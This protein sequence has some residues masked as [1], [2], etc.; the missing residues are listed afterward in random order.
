MVLH[1]LYTLGSPSLS[2]S[3][4]LGSPFLSTSMGQKSPSLSTSME[5]EISLFFPV[6]KTDPSKSMFLTRSSRDLPFLDRGLTEGSY[7]E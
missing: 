6:E 1:H 2:T 4:G 7:E 5:D 3:M